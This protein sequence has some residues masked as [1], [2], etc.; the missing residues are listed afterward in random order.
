MNESPSFYIMGELP[1]VRKWRGSLT[2]CG[3]LLA[4]VG[5]NLQNG[6]LLEASPPLFTDTYYN[7]KIY[8]IP[9]S[10]MLTLHDP[11]SLGCLIQ[12][13]CVHICLYGGMLIT[14]VSQVIDSDCGADLIHVATP[15]I[16][17]HC[18]YESRGVPQ[19]FLTQID[20]LIDNGCDYVRR[21]KGASTFP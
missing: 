11:R 15:L 18:E 9:Q 2:S 12:T 7:A 16:R 5:R 6:R 3:T 17:L 1:N 13:K 21:T 14:R 4:T 10:R 19:A 8:Q 20:W